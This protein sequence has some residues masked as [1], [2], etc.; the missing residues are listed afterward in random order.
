[1][2]VEKSIYLLEIL[3]QVIVLKLKEE[4]SKEPR[5]LL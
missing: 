2:V 5:E 4:V 1:M 3:N